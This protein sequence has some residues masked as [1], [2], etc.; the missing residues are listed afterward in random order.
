MLSIGVMASGQGQYYLKLAR[1]DYYLDGGE[2]VGRWWGRGAERLG[3]QPEQEVTANTLKSLLTGHSPAGDPLVQNAGSKERRP[4]FDLTFSAPKTVSALWA[5]APHDVRRDVQAC[6]DA[7][8][9]AALGYLENDFAFTRTGKAGVDVHRGGLAIALFEHGTSRALDPLL[10]THALLMNL[11]VTDS[12]LARALVHTHFFLQKMVAGALY[13]TELAA[14][15]IHRLGL[16]IEQ[17]HDAFRRGGMGF[18]L[19]GVS[20]KLCD[21]WS[22]RR[23]E[24]EK[25]LGE[26]G[27]ETASAAA[28]AALDTRQVKKDVPPRGELFKQWRDEG[29]QLGFDYE[30]FQKFERLASQARSTLNITPPTFDETLKKTLREL[31]AAPEREI[32]SKTIAGKLV[33]RIK[34][35]PDARAFGLSHFPESM[36]LR[37]LAEN[38]VSTG[39]DVSTIRSKLRDAIKKSPDLITI[40]EPKD[41]ERL[42]TTRSVLEQ[43]EKMLKAAHGLS[44][45]RGRGVDENAISRALLQHDAKHKD[46]PLGPERAA[47]VRYLTTRDEGAIRSLEGLAGTAKTSTLKIVKDLY[48]GEGY[49]VIGT[50]VSGKAARELANAWAEKSV[51]AKV[52][53]R[54][55]HDAVQYARAL[56]G[57]ST[58]KHDPLSRVQAFTLERF[59]LL[60]DDTFARKWAHHAEQIVRKAMKKTTWKYKPLKLDEKTVI[61]CDEASMVDTRQMAML[62]EKVK[63]SGATLLLVGGRQQ[64]QAV[65]R[66]GSFAHIA[67]R[68]GKVEIKDI[69]RQKDKADRDMVQD[70]VKGRMKKLMDDAQ[71]RGLLVVE[72]DGIKAQE[73]LLADWSKKEKGKNKGESLIFVGTRE[74]ADKVNRQCQRARLNEG[75]LI[76][77]LSVTVRGQTFHI[78]D[79]VIF[80]SP[81]RSPRVENGMMGTVRAVNPLPLL[82]TVG[83]KLDDGRVVTV[84]LRD[85]KD[86]KLGY[87]VTTHKGQGTT[88][89]RAYVLLGGSMQDKELSYVQ[90]SRA[91]GVTRLYTNELDAGEKLAKLAKQMERSNEKTLAT[92]AAD[93]RQL[94]MERERTHTQEH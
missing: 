59:E 80:N 47:A 12:G 22:K 84:P 41:T 17:D 30:T 13:R 52:I 73:K 5:V 67:D 48:E 53:N 86:L 1:E 81:G 62:V 18:K 14:Q 72:K 57:K 56:R 38:C 58:K 68:F 66:G 16:T 78:G 37:R 75:E 90:V 87:A 36:L 91:E 6:H 51:A 39:M 25:S 77:H 54:L 7:A 42:L 35:P 83:V 55:A 71:Q 63:A 69:V 88:V 79:R 33:Q 23:A 76:S 92:R 24:V 94:A 70:A 50:A 32:E 11:C 19:L 46:K 31:T 65:G 21:F 28:V 15:L 60:T 29:K 85:Y 4:G 34:H 44:I 8:V 61:V 9:K 49:R 26:R 3:L 89:K 10:H 74:D 43:E 2:P 93:R 20:A 82:K 40:D 27:L 45:S 64:L